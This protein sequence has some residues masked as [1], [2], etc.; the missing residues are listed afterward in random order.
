MTVQ[1]E[2]PGREWRDLLMRLLDAIKDD[3]RTMREAHDDTDRAARDA[4][5]K[6]AE[7]ERR[8]ENIEPVSGQVVELKALAKQTAQVTGS[9]WGAALGVAGSVLTALLLK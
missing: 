4:L 2:D 7:I 3:I 6:V 9:I 8:L 1:H 5:S